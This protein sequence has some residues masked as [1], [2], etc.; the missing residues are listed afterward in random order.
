MASTIG[1]YAAFVS[2]G[3]TSAALGPTLPTLADHVGVTLSAISMLFTA[4]L[5]GYLGGSLLGGRLYDHLPGHPLMAMGLCLMAGTMM[6]TPIVPL[7]EVL[8]GVI[9]LLGVADGLLDVGGNT[10]LVWVYGDRVGPRMNGL[11]CA[12]G[13]G[14]FVS[15]LLIAHLLGDGYSMMWAYWLLAALI[16][17]GLLWLV[18]CVSPEAPTGH[19]DNPRT[20]TQPFMVLGLAVFLSL[21]VG[22]EVSFG[23]WIFTY[24]VKLDLGHDT[25]AASLT[26]AFWGALTLG[27]LLAIPLATRWP[28][29]ALLLSAIGGCLLSV[30]SMVVQPPSILILWCGTCGAGL[31]MATVFPTTLALAERHMTITGRVTGWLLVG[32]STGGMFLPWFI[33]QLFDV[34]GPYAT[35]RI[36]VVDFCL[37]L[38]VLVL[39]IKARGSQAAP[40][41][42]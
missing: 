3:L 6:L 22:A 32:A 5:C 27:R 16:V 23:G 7:L 26:S 35:M 40:R 29:H 25:M 38:G 18:C 42:L 4:R 31:A 13:V 12:F 17:P 9:F 21:Y 28:P 15:P 24:A 39:V 1:Y 30:G 33:G 10:L 8:A 34:Y 41:Q 19:G 14:A 37:A 20:Q 36:M 11:H 2:L